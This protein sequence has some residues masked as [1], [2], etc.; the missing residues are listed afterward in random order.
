MVVAIVSWFLISDR[1][2][3]CKWL[4]PEEREL[5]EFRLV[6]ENVGQHEAVDRMHSKAVW[7]GIFNVNTMG[8]SMV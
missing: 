7:S 5:A 1:P 6:A 4:T 2:S 8:E 3:V